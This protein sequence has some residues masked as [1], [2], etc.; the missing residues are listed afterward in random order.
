MTSR[1][2][3]A[4]VINIQANGVVYDAVGNFSY[5]IGE[6]IRETLVGPDRIHGYKEL[7][8]E[9]YIEGE[10]RDDQGISLRDL[11]NLVDATITLELANGKT[12]ML[13]EAWY[14]AEGTAQ[15]E[16]A[17]VQFKFCGMSAEEIPV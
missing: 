13:R 17:N 4:G 15:S 8:Q 6:P 1:N 11:L 14:G 7:P 3:R 9:N 2:R 16:E 5:N 12:I 10:I